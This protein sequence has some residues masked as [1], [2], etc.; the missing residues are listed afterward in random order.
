MTTSL[1]PLLLAFKAAH[2]VRST[3]DLK[4]WGAFEVRIISLLMDDIWW[5]N[6]I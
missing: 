4:K 1:D 2:E 6:G 3:H 5:F